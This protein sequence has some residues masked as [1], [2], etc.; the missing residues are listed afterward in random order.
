MQCAQLVLEY[1][2]V[3]LSAPGVFGIIALV[4]LYLFKEATATGSGGRHYQSG[5]G[6]FIFVG[7]PLPELLFG[8]SYSKGARL[9]R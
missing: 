2:K 9:A 8:L 7:I 3:V 6:Y 4:V 5:T 1:V